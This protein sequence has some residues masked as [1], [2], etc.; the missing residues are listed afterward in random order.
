MPMPVQLF[1]RDEAV[2]P[3]RKPGSMKSAVLPVGIVRAT[4]GPISRLRAVHAETER[5]ANTSAATLERKCPP[6]RSAS[7]RAVSPDATAPLTEATS[8]PR[9][10][11]Q[12]NAES[13]LEHTLDAP[14]ASTD[15]GPAPCGRRT[16]AV[17]RTP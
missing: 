7:D 16:G 4:C 10:D 3:T 1:S 6:D 5:S 11:M 17:R 9:S 13:R 12:G 15:G 8:E 14:T 2:R